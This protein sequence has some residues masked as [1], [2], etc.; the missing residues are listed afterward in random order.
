MTADAA[1]PIRRLF[2]MI[3]CA[4]GRT[5]EVAA[6]LVD[7]IEECGELFSISG[8]YDLIGRFDLSRHDPGLFVTDHIQRVDGVV[9][10]HTIIAFNAF[11]PGA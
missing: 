9:S 10:T 6:R 1:S 5:Y 3:R 8:E 7:E 11:T 4:P 2:V